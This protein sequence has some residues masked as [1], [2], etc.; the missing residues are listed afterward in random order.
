MSKKNILTGL[1]IVIV[2]QLTVLASEYLGAIYPLW[3]GKEIRI[4]TR[5]VDPRSLFRGN[6]ARLQYDISTIGKNCFDTKKG[7]RNN[8]VIYVKLKPSKNGLFVFED[9]GLEKP[10]KGPFIRG[11]VQGRPFPNQ[12]AYNVRY[13]IEAYFAPKE[14]ALA[15]ERD[16]R[17]SGVAVIMVAE[18]GKA[19]LKDIVTNGKN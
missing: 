2:F 13:G 18:N 5:P 8:E 12:W 11:R 16:L 6:Y 19:A 14:K 9:A 1:M 3:T 7:L 17:R 10:E 4:R 15:L